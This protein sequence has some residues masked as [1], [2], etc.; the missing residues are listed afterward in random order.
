[1][2]MYRRISRSGVRHCTLKQNSLRREL[3]RVCGQCSEDRS[4]PTDEMPH[5]GSLAIRGQSERR[6]WPGGKAYLNLQTM[7]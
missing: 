3:Y 6:K 2:F 7:K 4:A 5:S 1:M